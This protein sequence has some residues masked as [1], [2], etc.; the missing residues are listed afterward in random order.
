MNH[1]LLIA[2]GNMGKVKE[3]RHEFALAAAQAHDNWLAAF[4]ILGLKDLPAL[5]L[6]AP[7]ECVEDQPTFEGNAGKKAAH[8]ARFAGMLTLAD[9]S[10]LCVDALGGAPGVYS[11][12][13]AG[14]AGHGADAA[15]NEKLLHALQDVPEA[16]RQAQFV[17][18]MALA[19]A[20]GQLLATA[21]DDVHGILLRTAR[22]TN[23]FGYDP[24]FYFPQFNKTTAELDMTTKSQI[25]HRG[26]AL[27]KMIAWL[28]QHHD[29][30]TAGVR[31]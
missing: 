2:T 25:S 19:S 24:L 1:R 8:Y 5:G 13:Y 11:A 14:V 17:C 3:I 10:G 31:G 12:R 15:N 21:R 6:G 20:D 29:K 27:R 23:G 26:K 4:N 7:P 22:G 28:R 9:D 18:V 16:R 30:M